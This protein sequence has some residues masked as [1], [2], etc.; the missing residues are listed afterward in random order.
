MDSTS[1]APV[2]SA[3]IPSTKDPD[4]LINQFVHYM[5]IFESTASD[6]DFWERKVNLLKEDV[7]DAEKAMLKVKWQARMVTHLHWLTCVE[8]L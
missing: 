6:A 5:D 8:C 3:L 4:A 2:D 1:G 7:S